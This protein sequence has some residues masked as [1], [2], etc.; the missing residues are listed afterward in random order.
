MKQ[1]LGEEEKNAL[2][3]EGI[4]NGHFIQVD[5]R[6]K[7]FENL[8]IKVEL[9]EHNVSS[10]EKP[11]ELKLIQLPSHLQYAYLEAKYKFYVIMVSDL[12]DE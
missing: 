12:S 1:E 8:E 6:I 3:R 2:V 11:S 4:V 5:G 7:H 9:V 10:I